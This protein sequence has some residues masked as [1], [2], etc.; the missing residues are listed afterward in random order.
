MLVFIHINKT[1]GRTVRYILRSSYGL[2]HCEVEPWHD[3][4][5]GPPFSAEDLQRLLRIY[6]NLS[7]IAGHRINGH[8]DLGTNRNTELK[9]FTFMRDPIKTCASRFQYNVQYRQKKNLV[10]EDW[11]QQD[12]T[13][14]HQTKMIAGVDDV[15]KA[16]QIIEEKNILVGLTER[17]DESM[18]LVKGLL[19]K[20]LNVSYER[21]NV[22]KDNTIARNL[23]DDER[24]RQ[25]I[26]DSQSA[27]IGLYN[28]VTQKLYPTFQKDYGISLEE[29]LA[30]YQH[31]RNNSFNNKNLTMSRLK[32]FMVYKPL[33]LLN[34]SGIRVI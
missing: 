21:V 25:L 20:D 34:R 16:I 24:S 17:F 19:A 1:A 30:N 23:L 15:D 26:I 22:A 11:I 5:K 28:Y 9:Y 3:K 6:P 7:S 33:L 2:S 27:D 29:D 32:Q 12:W 10:F 31:R 8:V 13:R 14:N 4:W 18:L